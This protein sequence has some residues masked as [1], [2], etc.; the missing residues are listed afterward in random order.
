MKREKYIFPLIALIS[1][2]LFSGCSKEPPQRIG[3]AFGIKTGIRATE[4]K[5]ARSCRFNWRGIAGEVEIF[6][7]P[8]TYTVWKVDFVA[9]ETSPEKIRGALLK[10]WHIRAVNDG[11]ITLPQSTITI[12]PEYSRGPGGMRVSVTD[13]AAA[14]LNRQECSM[15]EAILSQKQRE[16]SE[17][18]MLLEEAMEHFFTDTGTYPRLLPELTGNILQ[19]DKWN[20]PYIEKI[21]LDPWQMPFHY[22]PAPNGK[23]YELFSGGKNGTDRIR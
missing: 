20:G 10:E 13:N 5:V 17:N 19:R 16:A 7:T 9:T 23:S 2:V 4:K 18:I 3:T 22:L 14:K 6:C 21:P 12:S 1:T 11:K 15:P 8:H